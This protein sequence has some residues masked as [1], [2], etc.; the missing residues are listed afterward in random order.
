M[1]AA[2][3]AS[4]DRAKEEA[5]TLVYNYKK[6]RTAIGILGISLPFTTWLGALIVFQTKLQGSISGYY[7][8]GTRD[9]FVGTLWAIGFFF[10]AYKGYNK[11]EDWLGNLACLFAVGISIFPTTPE[12]NAT[13]AAT[14]IGYIHAGSAACFFAITA[15]FA[16][17]FTKSNLPKEALPSRKRNR[18]RVYKVCGTILS[19]SLVLI[20]VTAVLPAT[21]MAKLAVIRPVFLLE[22]IAILAF[23]VSWLVKGEAVM[24]D[25]PDTVSTPS[26]LTGE[27]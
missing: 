17:Q 1:S 16:F 6:L 24:G 27:A 14:R 18:N 20:V 22:T 15:V 25:N 9:V 13:A 4:L 7:Y 19:V 8:T 26:L 21:V 11:R 23:G 10:L 12:L 5:N 2:G 3:T